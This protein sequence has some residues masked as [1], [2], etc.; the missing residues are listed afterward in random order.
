M[1]RRRRGVEARAEEK[2]CEGGRESGEG[3]RERGEGRKEES[4]ETMGRPGKRREGN[5]KG[6]EGGPK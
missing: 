2:Q 5:H 3:E 1:R 6:G 4:E